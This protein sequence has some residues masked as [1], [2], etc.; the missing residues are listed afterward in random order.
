MPAKKSI[1]MTVPDVAVRYSGGK[2]TSESPLRIAR[3]WVR[4]RIGRIVRAYEG[5]RALRAL[6]RCDDRTL[7]ELGLGRADLR[8]A[9]AEPFYR[10]PTELLSGHAGAEIPRGG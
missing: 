5:R 1:S 4:G 10:D 3:E 6:A 8:G 7:R 9:A 2:Q